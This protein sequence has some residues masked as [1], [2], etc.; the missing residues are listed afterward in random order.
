MNFMLFTNSIG[1]EWTLTSYR[2]ASIIAS[3]MLRSTPALAVLHVG[4]NYPW[5]YPLMVSSARSL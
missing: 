4:F 2:M 1:I 5:V 3:S